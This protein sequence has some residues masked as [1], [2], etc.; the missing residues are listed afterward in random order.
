MGTGQPLLAAAAEITV[1]I[2]VDTRPHWNGARNFMRSI[3]EASAVGYHWIETLY[4]YVARWKDRPEELIGILAKLNLKMETVSNGGRMTVDFV[5]PAKRDETIASHMNL[6]RFIK[7]L[8]CDHL[9]INCGRR[10]GGG[11]TME[12]YRQMARGFDELGTRISDQGI[13]FGIHHHLSSAYETAQDVKT[14]MAMTNPDHVH[15]ILDTGHATMAGMDPMALIK[16]YGHRII[17]YHC[18]DCDPK[19]RGGYTGAPIDEDTVNT[20][21]NDRIFFEMGAGGVDF[22]GIVAHLNSIGWKGW[23]TV[24][25]DRTATTAK[26]SAM[27]NRKYIESVLKLAV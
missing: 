2:T 23:F 10:P 5:D 24:E 15:M 13:K 6:V 20:G 27:T 1:G 21:P 17:E 22:P 14:I 7:A 4:N 12:T 19:D 11:H 26:D 25:L 3:Q 9:K 16:T 18:K 8:G